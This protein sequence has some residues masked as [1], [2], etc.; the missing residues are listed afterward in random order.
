MKQVSDKLY[1]SAQPTQADIDRARLLGIVGIINNRPAG[2]EPAQPDVAESRA[3]AE[4]L[5]LKYW[6]VNC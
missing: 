1:T 5:G 6:H 3:A 2:E 4:G